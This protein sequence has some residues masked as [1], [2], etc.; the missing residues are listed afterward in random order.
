MSDELLVMNEVL[1][2]YKHLIVRFLHLKMNDLSREN[3]S[4]F[5]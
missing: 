5:F 1:F 2:L 4:K 3:I